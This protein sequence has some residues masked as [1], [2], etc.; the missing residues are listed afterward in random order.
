MDAKRYLMREQ[1]DTGSFLVWLKEDE[2]DYYLS[3]RV[4]SIVRHYR[5]NE[6]DGNFYLVQRAS[7]PEVKEL[8]AYYQTSQDGLCAQL[9]APCLKL[10]LPPVQSISHTTVDQ[11]EIDPDSIKKVRKLG[12]GRFG[13]VWLGLWN[14]TTEVAIKELQVTA[15]SLQK[16]LHG[17][18]ETMWRLSHEKLLK[19]YAVC[20]QTEP[21]FIVTEYMKHGTLKKYLR[22]HQKDRDL[23]F[24][25]LVDFAVQIAQGM[26]YMEQ[27]GCVHRDLRSENILLSA[28]MSC[29]IGDFGLAR[30]IDN[31][32]L[33]VS[34]DAQIP[35]KWTA[36]EVFQF[37]KFTSKSDVWSFGVLLVEIMTYG[38]LPFPDK[39]N[40]EYRQDILEGKHLKPPSES[41]E[42][43]SYIMEMCWRQE[44]TTRPSF[45]EIER[46]LMDLLK[47]ILADDT[48]E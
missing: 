6:S 34:L 2:E 28:M 32:S 9:M 14:G 37:Q 41:P 42:E 30:F 16:S 20:L 26:V 33:A 23:E 44:H 13:N 10:D 40:G 4:D 21:V 15:A 22:G 43:M 47:P 12:S 11:L 27:K 38:R 18:A 17:E 35:I 24:L 46:F 7:F 36:P 48:V 8:V 19:L 5:I 3:V 1:N 29:K 25:Q 39:S 45:Y 31:N